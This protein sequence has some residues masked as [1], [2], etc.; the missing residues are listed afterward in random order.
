[1]RNN[2]SDLFSIV[3]AGLITASAFLMSLPLGFL[4]LGIFL[5][6]FSYFLRS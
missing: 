2:L 6:V 1:M 4:V 3:G 5:L